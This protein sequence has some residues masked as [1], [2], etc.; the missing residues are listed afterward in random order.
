M[1][2]RYHARS[3]Q[4][5]RAYISPGTVYVPFTAVNFTPS[6]SAS[7]FAHDDC[8]QTSGASRLLISVLFWISVDVT[9]QSFG[10][11]SNRPRMV[12]PVVEES[13]T[14]PFA[15][16]PAHEPMSGC[17]VHAAMWPALVSPAAAWH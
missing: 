9:M 4:T 11:V 13:N 16:S 3:R 14:Q 7:G 15:V 10:S 6:E 5:P 17:A 1:L 12:L 2:E 8:V